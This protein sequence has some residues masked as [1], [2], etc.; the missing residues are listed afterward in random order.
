M[1]VN[2]YNLIRHIIYTIDLDYYYFFIV[3]VSSQPN[4]NMTG[5]CLPVSNM[6]IHFCP[7]SRFTY[8]QTYTTLT[9]MQRT[10]RFRLAICDL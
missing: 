5:S 6:N 7:I 8:K 9:L 10:C 1:V 3:H 4:V 2:S